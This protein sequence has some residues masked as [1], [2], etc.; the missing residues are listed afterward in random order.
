MSKQK[1]PLLGRLAVH[2]KL[3]TL[4][5]L[6]E[7][8]REQGQRGGSQNLGEILV[9]KGYL[10]AKQLAALVRAQ[11]EVVARERARRAAE[12]G[13]AA[14]PE[15]ESGAEGA[16]LEAAAEAPASSPGAAQRGAVARTAPP[17]AS[18]GDGAPA[19][20]LEAVL[21]DAVA[22][23][24]S[25]VHVHAGAPLRLRIHGRLQAAAGLPLDAGAAERLALAALEPQQRAELAQRGEI[26]L[27][28]ALPGIGAL[29]R[30]RVS[31]AARAS[32]PSS[33][34]SRRARRTSRI[35]GCR[36]ARPAHRTITRAWCSSP[37]RPAAAS[38]RRWPR[39]VDLVNEERREHMITIE[40]PIEYVHARSAASSTSAA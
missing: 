1:A 39:F 6:E 37:G 22:R 13:A 28:F 33:A 40:D 12:L 15:P 3:L 31:P 35:S 23:G 11:G 38:P 18:S 19:A 9:A 30:Q 29:P 14:A 25:D 5:Q 20:E 32:T 4:D 27:C 16:S 2:N 8:L 26:D 24:A 21:R 10:S 17:I 34:A 36:R 7:A